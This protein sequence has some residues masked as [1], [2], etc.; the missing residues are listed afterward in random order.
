M[1]PV[2]TY[3]PWKYLPTQFQDVETGDYIVMVKGTIA[4]IITNQTGAAAA[5]DNLTGISGGIP[6]ISGSGTILVYDDAT[7]NASTYSTVVIDDSYWGY[8]D[9]AVGLLV[10]ANGGTAGL[11]TYAAQDVTAG[12]TKPDTTLVV[13]DG[14]TVGVPANIPAG[15]VF[16]DIYQDIRGK[17]LNYDLWAAQYGI[18]SDGLIFVPY[19]DCGDT[20]P[21]SFAGFMDDVTVYRTAEAEYT[22]VTTT[23]LGYNAVYKKHAYLYFNSTQDTIAGQSGMLVQS[24][25]YGKFIPQGTSGSFARTEAVTAQTVG[26]IL[27]T[28]ARW[29]K[30]NEDLA[31]TYPGSGLQGSETGGIPAYIYNFAKDVMTGM[32]LGVSIS[33]IV[34]QVQNGGIGSAAIQIDVS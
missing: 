25:V 14:D 10:P 3:Y 32:S 13:Q 24:D 1:R 18:L 20:T 16:Q 31:D 21:Q 5:A 7:N 8:H 23:D 17:N 28:D 26:R 4:S 27:Y 9:S 15:I 22:I 6:D 12:V 29:P 19:I 11:Y 2:G 34:D 30:D 33:E